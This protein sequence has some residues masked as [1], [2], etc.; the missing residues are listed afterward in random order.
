LDFTERNGTERMIVSIHQPQYLPWLGYFD[1][2]SKSNAFVLLDNVQFKKNEWQNRN[3]IK[4]AQGWQWLTVPVIHRLS[5]KIYE[6]K[7]NNTVA[8]GKKHLQALITNYSKA[9][10]FKEH[11]AFFEQTY[12]QEWSSLVDINI[13]IIH[14]LAKA[15][16]LSDK[17]L[18]R[19]SGYELR[20]EATER[21]IDLCKHLRGDVYLSGKD[22][23]KYLNLALFEKE[24]IQVI[25]QDYQHPRYPQLYGDFEPYLSAIDL[26]FNCGSEGLS[27]LKKGG[28]N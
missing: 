27:I 15:L 8:W 14:Y 16:G 26:L 9:A 24:G 4:T 17:K 10:F 13:H 25:F 20:D 7:I 2:I 22:G 6:V 21:L 3:R 18:V 11:I 1:K 28:G 19:A 12:A 23:P 5:Q